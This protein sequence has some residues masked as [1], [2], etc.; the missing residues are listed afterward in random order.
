M[1]VDYQA[2]MMGVNLASGSVP[3][4]PPQWRQCK[5]PSLAPRPLRAGPGAVHGHS[6]SEGARGLA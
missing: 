2:I 5:G 1:L 6:H 3:A 4:V